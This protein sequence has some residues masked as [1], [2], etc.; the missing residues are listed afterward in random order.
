MD[1]SGKIYIIKSNENK[2][3]PA[4]CISEEKNGLF[5][6]LQIRSVKH[7]EKNKGNLSAFFIGKPAG[8]NDFSE[9]ML[10]RV[11]KVTVQGIKKELA[12]IKQII[13][14]NVKKARK[15]SLKQKR[16]HQELHNLKGRIQLAQMNNERY[17]HLE[18]KLEDVLMKLN[19]YPRR[20][21]KTE[22]GYEHYRETPY[23]GYIKVYLGGR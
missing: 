6:F 15:N 11:H 12:T 8:L 16:L 5:L 18:R 1:K 21:R 10:N 23:K 22:K 20:E 7:K 17:D 2:F 14:L 4:L 19:Y 13:L 9:V 3:V